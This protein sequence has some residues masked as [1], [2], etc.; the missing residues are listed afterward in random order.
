M[1]TFF[2][3]IKEVSTV[4]ISKDYRKR[5][6]IFLF[7]IKWFTDDIK[8]QTACAHYKI[9]KCEFI[10]F[11]WELRRTILAWLFSSTNNSATAVV[12]ESIELLVALPIGKVEGCRCKWNL[13]SV[14]R[15]FGVPGKSFPLGICIFKEIEFVSW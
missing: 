9:V 5:R 1:H 8:N 10:I 6:N 12:R 7:L 11:P 2:F 14:F 3:G 13:F 4:F 15:R